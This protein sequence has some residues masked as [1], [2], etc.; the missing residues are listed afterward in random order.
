[1]RV[2][3]LDRVE[4][5]NEFTSADLDGVPAVLDGFTLKFTPIEFGGVVVGAY[6][7]DKIPADAEVDLPVPQAENLI[8]LGLARLI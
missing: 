5:A 3:M 4:D 7:V 1:M 8:R 2:V 6:R